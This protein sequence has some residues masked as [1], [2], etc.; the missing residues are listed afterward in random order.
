M[1]CAFLDIKTAL[2]NDMV[3]ICMSQKHHFG[4]LWFKI[5]FLFG[6]LLCEVNWADSEYIS[7]QIS[8]MSYIILFPTERHIFKW[9]ELWAPHDHQLFWKLSSASMLG[10]LVHTIDEK[11]TF[12][13]CISLR[14]PWVLTSRASFSLAR[15]FNSSWAVSSLAD[16]SS[17]ILLASTLACY[18][19]GQ[20]VRE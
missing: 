20:W 1:F 11:Y 17:A 13:N 15:K 18:E 12:N 6:Q 10:P 14:S 2:R 16:M 7:Q 9:L 8:Y 19:V 5:K 3:E 4:N